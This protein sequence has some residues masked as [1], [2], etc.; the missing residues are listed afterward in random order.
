[1]AL[2]SGRKVCC[3]KLRL[4]EDFS[5]AVS[6]CKLEISDDAMNLVWLHPNRLL[7]VEGSCPDACHTY[8]S[9]VQAQDEGEYFL[10]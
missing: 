3:P 2:R 1:M 9:L 4:L 5:A 8:R 6:F 7:E 10:T